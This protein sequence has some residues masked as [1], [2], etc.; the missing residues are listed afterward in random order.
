MYTLLFRRLCGGFASAQLRG[1][2]LPTEYHRGTDRRTGW[3]LFLH[4]TCSC[5]VIEEAP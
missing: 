1:F 2:L 4:G 5:T 3:Q